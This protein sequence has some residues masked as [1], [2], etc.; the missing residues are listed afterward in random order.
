MRYS[1]FLP[2]SFDPAR[3]VALIAGKEL[4]PKLTLDSMRAAG[5]EVRLIGFEG[6]TRDDVVASFAENERVVIKV[7]QIGHMLK[8]IRRFQA[9]AAIMVGQVT[10]GRLFKGIHPDGKAVLMM[11]QLKKRNA[12]TIFGAIVTEIEKLGVTVLDAR[13]FLDHHLADEGAM[14]GGELLVDRDA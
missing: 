9:A 12:E 10:P 6:E 11:A 3:P 8:A 7:G 5:I 14:T 13:S 2:V 1:R 4:Y